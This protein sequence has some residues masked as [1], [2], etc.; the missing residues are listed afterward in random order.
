MRVRL[1]ELRILGLALAALWLAAFGLVLVGYRPGGPADLLVGVAAVGPALIA[2]AG[3]WWPPAARGD[4]AFAG[5]AW[6]ALASIEQIVS[7][8][9]FGLSLSIT[10]LLMTVVGGAG[11]R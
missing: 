9:D 6:L 5:I 11:N 4:R 2:L 8:E 1:I 10:F 3:V 7:K